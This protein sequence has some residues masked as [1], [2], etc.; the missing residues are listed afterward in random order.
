MTVKTNRFQIGVSGTPANNFTLATPDTPDGSMKLHRG[1]EGAGTQDILT[2]SA[3]GLLA[4]TVHPA[5]LDRSGALAT[6]QKFADEFPVSKAPSGWQK[7]PSGLIVQWGVGNL[8]SSGTTDIVGAIT[9]PIAFPSA[10]LQVV[11]SVTG[12]SAGAW[13][14][15]GQYYNPS[16]PSSF[17]VI[18]QGVNN[19]TLT[20][21]WLAIGY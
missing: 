12:R 14:A 10:F 16:N 1:N 19:T 15:G 18:F 17:Q 20:F 2:V 13:P 21:A 11:G 5:T 8:S 9:L 6:M 3:A 4:A 7:L